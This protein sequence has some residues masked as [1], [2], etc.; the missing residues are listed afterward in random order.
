MKHSLHPVLISTIVAFSIIISNTLWA[1]P[2]KVKKLPAK[3]VPIKA[4]L[5]VGVIK[6][7]PQ[8]PGEG[9]MVTFEGNVMNYGVGVAKNPVAIL[10]VAGPAG[11]N[12]P[13]FRKEFNVTLT[14]N[15]GVTLVKKFKVPKH[16]NYTCTL[17]LD[18]ADMIAETNNNNNKKDLTFGVR[19]RPDL[20]VCI[21]N[22]KRPPVGGKRTI[23]AVIKNIGSI[24]SLHSDQI[25]LTFYVEGKGTKTYNTSYLQQG[26]SYKVTRKI[27]WSTSGT[28]TITAKITY[29][30][31]EI[32]KTNNKVSGSYFVRLPHHDKYA[33][34]PKVKCSD[35]KC[36]TSWN[37]CNNQY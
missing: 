29:A 31:E 21:S 3:I 22:A 34:G 13:L 33:A 10:T 2:F 19:A 25:K 7:S 35:N 12:I 26:D 17:N 1:Q 16:G 24:P 30:G 11:V 6:V 15:Q 32:C 4:D 28:K 5:Q 14:K 9:Q 27:K 20:I 18:P 23:D 8:N 36:F 37:Q